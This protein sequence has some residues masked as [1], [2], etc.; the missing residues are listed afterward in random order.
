MLA[1]LVYQGSPLVALRMVSPS[2]EFTLKEDHFRN[3]L[4]MANMQKKERF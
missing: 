3:Y 2:A 1:M 4:E